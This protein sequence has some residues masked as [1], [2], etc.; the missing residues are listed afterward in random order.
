MATLQG[1]T[2]K[3][4]IVCMVH[5]YHMTGLSVDH[6]G[7]HAIITSSMKDGTF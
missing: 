7:F 6:V 5:S 3:L 1:A 4:T 2:D